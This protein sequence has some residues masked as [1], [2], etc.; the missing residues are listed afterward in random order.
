MKGLFEYP[1]DLKYLNDTIA[2]HILQLVVSLSFY[3]L[4]P[5]KDTP[6]GESLPAVGVIVPSRT[7]G[8]QNLIQYTLFP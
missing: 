3:T 7:D 4:K 5:E 6:S 8:N 1:N 2:F